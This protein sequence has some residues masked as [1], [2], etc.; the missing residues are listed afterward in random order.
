M[1]L[2][3]VV[4][5]ENSLVWQWNTTDALSFA[6]VTVLVFIYEIAEV[7]N[8]VNAVLVCGITVGVKES[9]RFSLVST[10]L[11]NTSGENLRKLLQE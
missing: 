5:R 9:E 10:V 6:V 7:K 4:E 11:K 8:I 1:S 3:V 2:S